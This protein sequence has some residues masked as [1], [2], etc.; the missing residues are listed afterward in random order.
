MLITSERKEQTGQ[1]L[2]IFMNRFHRSLTF[3][4]V[5]LFIQLSCEKVIY[6]GYS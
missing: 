6:I 3:L 4:I 1:V 5:C 2:Y